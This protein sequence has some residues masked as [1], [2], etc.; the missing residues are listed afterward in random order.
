MNFKLGS[1]KCKRN[2]YMIYDVLGRFIAWGTI[3]N[4]PR[5]ISITLLHG[6]TFF[7]LTVR[8]KKLETIFKIGL[9]LVFTRSLH[10]TKGT[11]ILYKKGS[12][13]WERSADWKFFASKQTEKKWITSN[14]K[15]S[16]KCWNC[17]RM[18][19]NKHIFNL[20]NFINSFGHMYQT[21]A[22]KNI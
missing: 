2:V 13:V 6:I 10:S 11:K 9:T 12:T 17:C 3:W 7:R 8:R 21:V 18:L 20:Q 16:W 22:L 5:H 15:H 4:I 19:N 1:L 14:W